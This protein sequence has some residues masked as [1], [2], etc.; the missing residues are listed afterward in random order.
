[1]IKKI[2]II[3]I[4]LGLLISNS[5][6]ESSLNKN[7]YGLWQIEN[8]NLNNKDI[9]DSLSINT[10]SFNENSGSVPRVSNYQKDG[11]IEWS[12]IESENGDSIFIKSKNQVFHGNYKVQFATD[13]QKN[14]FAKLISNQTVIEI[15]KIEL[16]QYID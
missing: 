6:C 15:R 4:G 12:I 16:V 8:L 5:S 13:E 10:I 9:T 11:N 7:I 14:I 1:M 3:Q 2:I